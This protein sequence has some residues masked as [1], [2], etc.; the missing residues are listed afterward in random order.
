MGRK[1]TATAAAISKDTGRW[2]KG[3]VIGFHTRLL[4]S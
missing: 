3:S 2:E 4:L 1:S